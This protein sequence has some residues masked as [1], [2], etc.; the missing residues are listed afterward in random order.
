MGQASAGGDDVRL[1]STASSG[2]G[3]GRSARVILWR[4]PG[5]CWFQSVKAAWPVRTL[6]DCAKSETE[7]QGQESH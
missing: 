6:P 3:W 5:C 4:T 2:L 1:L 7:R